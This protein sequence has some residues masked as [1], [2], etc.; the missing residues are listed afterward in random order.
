MSG[1]KRAKLQNQGILKVLVA[2]S[3]F[4]RGERATP[5]IQVFGEVLNHC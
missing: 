2:H 1:V 5:I 4:D 3:E